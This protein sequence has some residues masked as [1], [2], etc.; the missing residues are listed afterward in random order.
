MKTSKL[1]AVLAA[2]ALT[3]PAAQAQNRPV[4]AGFTPPKYVMTEEM[5]TRWAELIK[6]ASDGAIDWEIFVNGS[7]VPATGTLEA[8]GSGI[9]Q[10]GHIVPAYF[11]SNLPIS[12]LINDMGALNPDPLVLA[13]AYAD[14]TVNEPVG[15]KEFAN[16]DIL[17]G[18]GTIATPSYNFICRGDLKTAED[19]QGKRVRTPGGA[20]S[21]FSQSI[22]MVPVNLTSSELYTA[23]ERGAVDC[24]AGDLSLLISFDLA[25]LADSVVTLPMPP[26]FALAL[27]NYNRTYWQ[28]LSEADRRIHLD[29]TARSMARGFLAFEAQVAEGAILAQ[30]KGIAL[31]APGDDLVSAFDA[32]VADG[33]G[34]LEAIGRDQFGIE[35]AGAVMASFEPYVEKWTA[36]F[37]G[38]DRTSEDAITEVIKTNL[39]DRIDVA[40]YGID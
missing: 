24:V 21:R 36:L 7:L 23:M 18:A 17:Y 25:G 19:L 20:L 14:F 9:A 33:F 4:F 5:Q 34:G 15:L 31:N 13:S 1:W 27:I 26:L 28:G 2:L 30:E 3:A 32:W 22:G 8:V 11:P 38:V 10:A 12:N 16:N 6:E 35:D 37:E 39:H 40:T 29:A